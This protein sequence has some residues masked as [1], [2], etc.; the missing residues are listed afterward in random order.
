[1]L[2]NTQAQSSTLS[3]PTTK[4]MYLLYY[5]L[6]FNGK[7]IISCISN[8]KIKLFTTNKNKQVVDMQ[9]C[10]SFLDKLRS[11]VKYII[12]HKTHVKNYH[13]HIDMQ[14]VK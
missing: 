6:I 8:V 4:K 11:F 10:K 1:M 7:Y 14:L 3:I 9:Y 2:Q 5:Q 12:V 13:L